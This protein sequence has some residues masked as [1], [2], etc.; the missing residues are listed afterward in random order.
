MIAR[1]TA[2]IRE[3]T[4]GVEAPQ[5]QPELLQAVRAGNAA[6]YGELY[7]RPSPRRPGPAAPSGAPRGRAWSRSRSRRSSSLV[8]RGGGPDFRA[9]PTCSPSCGAQSMT[10][11][12][13]SRRGDHRRDRAVRPRGALASTRRSSAWRS[14]ESSRPFLSLH[15]ALAGGIVATEVEQ[16][17]CGR[18]GAA[19]GAVG[20]RRRGGAGLPGQGGAAASVP[21][22]SPGDAAGLGAGRCWPRWAPMLH[23]RAGQARL[24][25]DRRACGRLPRSA[26]A[27]SCWAWTN[28]NRGPRVMIR[29]LHRRAAVRR[30]R[31]TPLARTSHPGGGP[32]GVLRALG[33]PAAGAEGATGGGEA[34]VTM[35]VAAVVAAAAVLLPV[36]GERPSRALLRACR[37]GR[38]ASHEGRPGKVRVQVPP[39]SQAM[40]PR[41]RPRQEGPAE[42][43]PALGHDRRARFP[44]RP[45][46]QIL[47]LRLRNYGD[48]P[49]AELAAQVDLPARHPR[50]SARRGRGA[51]LAGSGEHGG[52]MDG[53]AC[54]PAEAA[55]GAPGRP[56]RPGGARRC[57]CRGAGGRRGAAGR[58]IAAVRIAAGPL[59]VLARAETGVRGSG[60]P[61]R[62]ATDG[63]VAVRAIGNALLSCPRA[64]GL[65]GGQAA[66]GAQRD[67]DLWP[68]TTLDQDGRS[69]T[70][71]SSRAR[72]SVPKSSRGHC[73]RPLLV[74]DGRAG[75]A[76]QAEPPG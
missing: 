36:S 48:A 6:A 52:L 70:A 45:A 37:R 65:P 71:S 43:G 28:I 3:V 66:R 60:A 4:M 49:S 40:R 9:A 20:Q 73:R 69:D 16:L 41:C 23:W 44:R 21:A 30:L 10:S 5:A 29:P 56:W 55:R 35:S 50:P 18:G 58:E 15:R 67:S 76:D 22:T 2:Y 14:P 13:S 8:G 32:G 33:W 68:M 74:G 51:A 46:Q 24:Q 53:W 1:G 17:S 72:L 61:A 64:R 54:R 27:V 75:R 12:G 31:G 11:P 38:A 63:K 62:F 7:E 42:T 39:R 59:R 34:G 26:P 25:G 47:A 19:A 57:S